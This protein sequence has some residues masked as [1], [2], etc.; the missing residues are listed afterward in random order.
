[1]PRLVLVHGSVVGGRAT[2]AGQRP[3]AERF[4]LVV[5]DRPGFPPN[6]PVDRVDFEPDAQL[7]ARPARTGRPPRRSLVRRCRLAP[8]RG[9]SPGADRLA[10]GHRASCN[11]GRRGRSCRRRLRR[12]GRSA[13]RVGSDERRRGVPAPL[14]RSGRLG[15]RPAHPAPARARPGSAGPD[16]R[17]RPVG[18]G[19][20]ARLARRR[21]LPEARR[22]RCAPPGVRRDLRRPRARATCRAHRPARATATPSSATPR[23]T[24]SSP[25]SS[26]ERSRRPPAHRGEAREPK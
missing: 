21:V 3:L 1:M 12:R 20:P 10:D 17:A 8:R 16:R 15:V 6:P 5:V 14:P 4:E 24:T 11:P 23:S 25:T 18:G 19:D 2:W 26:S 7:V 22:L 9:G 13:L